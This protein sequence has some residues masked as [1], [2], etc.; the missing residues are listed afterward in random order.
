M[1]Q[2]AKRLRRLAK[3]YATAMV[4]R[5]LLGGSRMHEL[6]ARRAL[7]DAINEATNDL[8]PVCG[9]PLNHCCESCSR[10]GDE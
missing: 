4:T 1:N 5:N 7:Y 10:G 8:C 6:T 3:R 9:E 2:E